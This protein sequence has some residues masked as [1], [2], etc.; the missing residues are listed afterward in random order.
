MNI[1]ENYPAGEAYLLF[2]EGELVGPALLSEAY[3]TYKLETIGRVRDI[4]G[5]EG[6]VTPKGLLISDD[7]DFPDMLLTK[8]SVSDAKKIFPHTIRKFKT[9][10]SLVASVKKEIM[11]SN[12]YTPIIDETGETVSIT[13][14]ASGNVLE[15]IRADV[16]GELYYRS[17]EDWV[18]VGEDDD[19]P[20]IFDQSVIDIDVN[21]IDR[22]IEYYDKNINA[23]DSISK[24]EMLEFAALVQ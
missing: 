15:L 1:Y 13:V 12:S 22:A 5:F 8:L 16:D 20:T 19:A 4:T 24:E 17:N 9:V 11:D 14:D 23:K 7:T 3:G 6:R 10:D 18:L 21:D 2:V